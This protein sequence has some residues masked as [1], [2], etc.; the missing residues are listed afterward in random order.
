MRKISKEK[1]DKIASPITIFLWVTI[2][3]L[4]TF[5][6]V[7]ALT[8]INVS[9]N[10]DINNWVGLVVEIGIGAGITLT[11]WKFSK[12]DQDKIKELIAE[13]QKMEKRQ[14]DIIEQQEQFR[15]SRERWAYHNLI[16][17][18]EFLKMSIYERKRFESAI[19]ENKP[20]DHIQA[21]ID[22]RTVN[23]INKIISIQ[24]ENS[25]VI[26]SE[27]MS[28]IESILMFAKISNE[29]RRWQENDYILF[30]EMRKEINSLLEKLRQ[31]HPLT[32]VQ[33]YK[34]YPDWS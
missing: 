3:I 18:L 4:I 31:V 28:Q 13:I 5:F 10:Q 2:G 32:V 24:K 8:G 29:N 34:T 1:F 11:V 15:K 14:T 26:P 33:P 6:I 20:S 27:F 22:M 30:D 12:R 17:E 25:D 16:S 19:A 23:T 7:T 9:N 21:H